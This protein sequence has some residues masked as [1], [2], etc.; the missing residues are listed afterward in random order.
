[1]KLESIISTTGY[2]SRLPSKA[3]RSS[4][5]RLLTRGRRYTLHFLATSLAAFVFSIALPAA[6]QTISVDGVS[7]Q[8]SVLRIEGEISQAVADTFL[9]A[10]PAHPDLKKVSLNS[11]G[12]RVFP[13]LDIARAIRAAGL[14]TS[15]PIADQ[16]HSACSLIFLAGKERIA[17]GKLGVHQISGITD[18]SLTQSA[19]AQIYEYLVSFN[20]P[21]YLVSRMLRTP[22]DDMYVFSPE[23]L[24]RNAINMRDANQAG[25]TPHLQAIETWLRENWLVGVFMNTHTNTP[26]VA[27]E[28]REMNPLGCVDS[29]LI[30]RTSAAIVTTAR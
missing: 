2:S 21:S 30:H 14:S 15:V 7:V 29:Y 5:H 22:P 18:P 10:M 1:V 23:E 13:A 20:T 12:G 6:S 19:I 16:C 28:S 25:S 17:D 11:P 27:L 26:F 9:K 4:A 24:E 3:R 8:G